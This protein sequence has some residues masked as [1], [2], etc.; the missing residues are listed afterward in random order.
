MLL[1]LRR[2]GPASEA[3]E[4]AGAPDTP[5]VDEPMGH[6][7]P[8]PRMRPLWL[9]LL[10][11]F[12]LAVAVAFC[13][14]AGLALAVPGSLGVGPVARVGA[15]PGL[16]A[17]DPCAPTWVTGWQAAPQ[18]AEPPAG[19]AGATLR[20]IVHPQLAGSQVR[21]R[22]SNAYGQTP[23]KVG[24]VTV[25]RS[26]GGAELV[27]DSVRPATFDEEVAVTVPAG[28]DVLS[29]PIAMDTAAG[30]PLAVSL[31]LAEVPATLT[32]HSVALQNSYLSGPADA[33]RAG[34]DA[35]PGTVGSW[36][37]LTGLDVFAD[38]P[39]NALVAVG[40]SITDGVGSGVGVDQRWTDALARRLTDPAAAP[41]ASM[42]VLNAGIARNRLLGDDPV[43]DGDSPLT[44]F[45]RDVAGAAGASDVVLHIGTN[46]IAVGHTAAEIV[47]GLSGYV[48]HARAAGKRV[49][50]TTITPS[51]AGAHG[52]RGAISARAAVNAWVRDQGP[53]VADGVF[54]FA[55]AVADPADPDRLAPRFDS[56]DGLHLSAAGYQALAAAVD[57]ARLTG[58]PCRADPAITRTA[59]AGN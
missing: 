51:E 10:D 11:R 33:S 5:E 42:V 47:E 58:S 7:H 26:G 18:A 4:R 27:A 32:Q 17:A 19:L 23:L 9:L 28:E 45:D 13:C 48:V 25:G 36:S 29:D 53:T 57:P 39:T 2:P 50:L 8:R 16:P 6:R 20:M 49:F 22:L 56:G 31:F 34:A 43:R 12:R 38:A 14:A 24:A 40:D 41:T 37:V 59:V 54:D 30:G 52:T 21:V 55:A 15:G 1:V 46:D 35:F 44:R 3:G